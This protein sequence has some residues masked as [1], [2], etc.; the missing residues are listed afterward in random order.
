MKDVVEQFG[1]DRVLY[2]LAN[3]VRHFDY[4][5]RLSDDNKRWAKT[6]PVF[7][8][9]DASG[10]D[11][12]CYFVVNSHPGLTDLF[13]K[14]ARR[15]YL[16][17]QPLTKEEIH[18]EAAR[19]LSKLQAPEKPNSPNSTHFMAE[20]S[21][22]FLAR[23]KGKDQDKL[24]TLLPFDT[25]TFSQLNDR[26]GVYAFIS[27]DENRKQPLQTRRPSVRDKL[28]KTTPAPKAPTKKKSK[29]M[30]TSITV[31]NYLQRTQWYRDYIYAVRIAL[32]K[33]V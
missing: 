21:P 1:F 11:R 5:G 24:F 23:A 20:V 33:P 10:S 29:D 25:L 8:N 18:M 22:D 3:T 19:I 31:Q 27:A 4:D 26:K 16:L 28:Q 30:R 2:V 6:V 15:E 13:V 12:N 17:T 14:Q 7:E 9:P 32:R